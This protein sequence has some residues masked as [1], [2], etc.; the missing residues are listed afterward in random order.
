M[1]TL[2]KRLHKCNGD[3]YDTIH[4]E[5]S[6]DCVL[7][8][9]GRTVENAITSHREQHF[10]GGSDPIYFPNIAFLGDNPITIENDTTQ[11][12]AATMSGYAWFSETGRL[13][14]QPSQYGFLVNYAYGSDVFQIY[15]IQSG[16]GIYVR[17]GNSAGWD[18]TWIRVLGPY[19]LNRI[20]T[21]SGVV[22]PNTKNFLMT[23]DQGND[24]PAQGALSVRGRWGSVNGTIFEVARGWI[25]S[26][27]YYPA[28][29]VNGG[30]QTIVQ[31]SNI[32]ADPGYNMVRNIKAGTDTPTSLTTGD[33]YL[34]Y[35]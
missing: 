31:T 17:G 23:I 19:D 32:M 2:K 30:G 28:L 3:G 5:T 9:D 24:D 6:A 26:Q 8:S 33:I 1:A 22:V 35:E 27:G 13:T 29:I 16:G 4:F 7:M 20:A 25:S 10:R 12:W 21:G 18:G 15:K 14:D 34:V 11:W